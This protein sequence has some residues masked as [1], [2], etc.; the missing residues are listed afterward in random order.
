MG[1]GPDPNVDR[2]DPMEPEYWR[3]GEDVQ[4]RVRALGYNPVTVEGIAVDI[5]DILQI[6]DRIRLELAPRI[7]E[8]TAESVAEVLTEFSAEIIHLAWHC[9]S[10]EAYLADAHQTI[11]HPHS[12]Q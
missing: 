3:L 9:K 1:L 4:D 8:A 10:A 7:L 12:P 6:A 5:H 2:N 11:T